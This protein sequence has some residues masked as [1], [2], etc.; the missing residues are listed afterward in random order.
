MPIY[1]FNCE[2]CNYEY[3]QLLKV[4]QVSCCPNCGSFEKQKKQLSM[5]QSPKMQ[6]YKEWNYNKTTQEFLF[7][8]DGMR[9][10]TEYNHKEIDA[11]K[12]EAKKKAQAKGATISV[13]KKA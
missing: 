8:G 13:P 6:G 10:Q 9:A 7:G 12:A 1:R 2:N 5:P 4:D 11:K 3:S